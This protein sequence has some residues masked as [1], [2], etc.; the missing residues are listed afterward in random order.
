MG[1]ARGCIR[2]FGGDRKREKPGF[3]GC[4]S[5]DF[6]LAAGRPPGERR[7]WFGRFI[8]RKNLQ[9]NHPGAFVS[10]AELS[11]GM[12]PEDR[13]VPGAGAGHRHCLMFGDR[14]T[15]PLST[16]IE[17]TDA[18]SGQSLLAVA[19]PAIEERAAG[20]ISAGLPGAALRLRQRQFQSRFGPTSTWI[21]IVLQ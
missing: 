4:F 18:F 3:S 1:A 20:L 13:G 16:R 9:P 14:E 8:S 6:G 7:A 12:R 2:C 11:V 15:N 10:A 5:V 17:V 19:R 21:A